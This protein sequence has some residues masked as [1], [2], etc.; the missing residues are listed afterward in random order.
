MEIW[1][2]L[3][4]FVEASGGYVFGHLNHA[5]GLIGSLR[6]PSNEQSAA[7]CDFN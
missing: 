5:S 4:V 6:L 1:E 2:Q 3:R 7:S